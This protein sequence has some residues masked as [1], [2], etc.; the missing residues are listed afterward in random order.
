MDNGYIAIIVLGIAVIACVSA[1]VAFICRAGAEKNKATIQ[2]QKA[3]DLEAPIPCAIQSDVSIGTANSEPRLVTPCSPAREGA[4]GDVE[5]GNS[6]ASTP[7]SRSTSVRKKKKKSEV[8][9]P[10]LRLPQ[11]LSRSNSRSNRVAPDEAP[12]SPIAMDP[13]AP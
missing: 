13:L 2:Q 4:A 12:A 8:T 9:L 11:S 7:N 1:A 5:E 6:A 10:E 3:V